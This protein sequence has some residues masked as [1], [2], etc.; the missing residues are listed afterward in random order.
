M[1]YTKNHITDIFGSMGSGGAANNILPGV[2]DFPTYAALGLIPGSENFYSVGYNASVTTGE[3]IAGYGN[4][5]GPHDPSLLYASSNVVSNAG[6]ETSTGTIDN[7]IDSGLTIVDESAD[8]VTD[9]VEAGAVF[10]NDTRGSHVRIDSFTA[11]TITFKTAKGYT[12]G[13]TYRVAKGT[14][15]GAYL[16]RY[17]TCLKTD[18][19]LGTEYVIL[20]GTTKVP[21]V[22]EYIAVNEITVVAGTNPDVIHNGVI[23]LYRGVG[24]G[25]FYGVLQGVTTM[26]TGQHLNSSVV[27]PKDH[28]A[29]IYNVQITID[30]TTTSEAEATIGLIGFNE[31]DAYPY[32]HQVG[33]ALFDVSSSAPYSVSDRTM[34]IVASPSTILAFRCMAATNGSKMS[35]TMSGVLIPL[36]AFA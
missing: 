18:F 29:V 3:W 16:L 25:T 5:P 28:I 32:H 14:S 30:K 36:S 31:V 2:V 6:V 7:V 26:T 9:G 24:G 21:T 12:P 34:P 10:I 33:Y 4:S 11:T 1:S 8:F 17:D 13:D 35:T 22:N 20:D 23:N 27:V 19:T 15:T